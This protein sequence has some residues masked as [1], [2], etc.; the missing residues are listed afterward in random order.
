M[1]Q[2]ENYSDWEPLLL[3][4]NYVFAYADGLNR[5]YVAKEHSELLNAFKYPPNVFDKFVRIEQKNSEY[6]ANET[7]ARANEA[8]NRANEINTRVTA[9][10][11]S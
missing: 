4:N 6:Q 3:E 8:E 9:L 11:N 1:S 2:E 5:F 10:L 7:Q